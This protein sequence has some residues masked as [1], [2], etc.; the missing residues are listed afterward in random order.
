MQVY[1]YIYFENN[2][3]TQ[4]ISKFC[5]MKTEMDEIGQKLLVSSYQFFSGKPE[6]S[7][8]KADILVGFDHLSE[9]L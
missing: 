5:S 6:I 7:F 9:F 1:Q 8:H 3:K 4:L 2:L